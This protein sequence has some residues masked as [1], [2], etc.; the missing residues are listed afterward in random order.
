MFPAKLQTS[1]GLSLRIHF[2]QAASGAA[3]ASVLFVHGLGDHGQ[4]LPYRYLAEALT[5]SGFG[6][7]GFDL[8][9]HGQSDGRRLYVETW[10]DFRADLR[11]VV[12]HVQP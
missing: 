9:G 10:R 11:L 4:A 8:R 2:F 5:R 6:V 12:E 3:W 1:D 7:Y